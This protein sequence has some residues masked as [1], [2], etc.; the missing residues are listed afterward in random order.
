MIT[1]RAASRRV[2]ARQWARRSWVS[3]RTQRCPCRVESRGALRTIGFVVRPAHAPSTASSRGADGPLISP[4]GDLDRE[5]RRRAGNDQAAGLDR[6]SDRQNSTDGRQGSPTETPAKSL[7]ALQPEQFLSEAG[8]SDLAQGL[9]CLA[10]TSI[11]RGCR[12]GVALA[13]SNAT[14][15]TWTEIS[16]ACACLG[17]VKPL[18]P[19]AG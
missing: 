13:G 8:E 10:N 19:R 1:R 15:T 4:S 12:H 18:H 2:V 11:R 14:R 16:H 17:G 6:S 3:R 9:R 7:P 5:A